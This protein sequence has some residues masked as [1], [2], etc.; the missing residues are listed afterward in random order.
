MLDQPSGH[1][2][3]AASALPPSQRI[4]LVL[5]GVEDVARSAQFYEALGWRRSPTGNDGFV[6]FIWA[7]TRFA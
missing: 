1:T 2:Y 7:V 6:K 3:E 5:L 4:H